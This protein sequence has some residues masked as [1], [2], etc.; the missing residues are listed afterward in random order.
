[1]QAAHTLRTMNKRILFHV[2][3]T[4]CHAVWRLVRV[5]TTPRPVSPCGMLVP[6]DVYRGVHGMLP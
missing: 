3:Q 5:A 2:F 6:S 4:V 1:M